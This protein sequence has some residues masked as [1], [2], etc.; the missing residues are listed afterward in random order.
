M[1]VG[2]AVFCALLVILVKITDTPE[3]REKARLRAAIDLCWKEQQRKS[4]DS[5][6]ARIMAGVCEGMESDFRKRYGH[7]P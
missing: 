2:L 5:S 7:N 4:I 3:G 1:L 6:T